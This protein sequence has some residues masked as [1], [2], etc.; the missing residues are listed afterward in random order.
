M[1]ERIISY[2]GGKFSMAPKL[3]ELMPEHEAYFEPFAGSLAVFFT[4]KKAKYNCVNDLDKDIANLYYVCSKDEL[5]KQFER[6][7]FFLVQSRDIYNIIRKNINEKKEEVIIPNP[8]RAAEYFFFITNS[9]NNRPGTSLSSSPTWN[10]NVL[11]D[12]TKAR[13]KLDNVLIENMDVI[14]MI[15]KYKHKNNALWFFDPP[16]W[17][18]NG[19]KYYHHVFNIKD[20]KRFLNGINS[21]NENPTVKWMITY[22]ESPEI[23]ELFKDYYIRNIDVKYT[24]TYEVMNTNE[25]I[26]SNYELS[27][28]QLQLF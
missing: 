23:R 15:E 9:F 27:D 12:V 26:I 10:T 5:Y 4:K 6:S 24:S 20:H 14:D 13:R 21:L 18:A 7:V 22:D 3:I 25:I 19:S 17:V 2:Y 11:N 28:G 1:S 16:Y 8:E